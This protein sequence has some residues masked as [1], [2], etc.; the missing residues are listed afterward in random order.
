MVERVRQ[1]VSPDGDRTEERNEVRLDTL[2]ADALADEARA[3]GLRSASRHREIEPT[4]EHVGQ[5]R[6]QVL[7]APG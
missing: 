5:H 2:D 7:R 1:I 3:D 4:H 6:R